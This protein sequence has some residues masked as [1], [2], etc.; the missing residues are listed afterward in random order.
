MPHRCTGAR[1]ST[2]EIVR[3]LVHHGIEKRSAQPSA[4][5]IEPAPVAFLTGTTCG[6]EEERGRYFTLTCTLA[7]DAWRVTWSMTPTATWWSPVSMSSWKSR[8]HPLSSADS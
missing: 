2:T 1:S 7:Y 3:R 8:P 6:L 5:T 4:F